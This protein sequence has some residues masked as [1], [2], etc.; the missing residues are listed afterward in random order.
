MKRGGGGLFLYMENT[1]G[2]PLIHESG[3]AGIVSQ[4]VSEKRGEIEEIPEIHM[5]ISE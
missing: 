3:G 5:M 1:D 4:S 2:L